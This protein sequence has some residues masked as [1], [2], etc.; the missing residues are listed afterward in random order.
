MS[1]IKIS[2]KPSAT[3]RYC[4]GLL[5]FFLL[6]FTVILSQL[7]WPQ[8]ADKISLVLSAFDLFFLELLLVS[9]LGYFLIQRSL[10]FRVI[11]YLFAAVFCL[12][13]LIQTAAFYQTGKFVTKL[14]VENINHVAIIFNTQNILLLLILLSLFILFVWFVEK[15]K[16][17]SINTAH[18]HQKSFILILG[19]SLLIVLSNALSWWSESQLV[20]RN[21]FLVKNQLQHIPPVL[22]FYKLFFSKT[23]QSAERLT[24]STL[25]TA[26]NYGFQYKEN[27]QYPLIK[28]SIYHGETPFL[29]HDTSSNTQLPNIIIFFV[30]GFSARTSD[31][32]STVYKDITPNLVDFAKH[33]LVIDNYYNHTAATYRGL[34]GQLCSIYPKFGG[35][36]GGWE[37]NYADLPH[38]NYFCLT[39]ELKNYSYRSIFLHSQLAEKTYLNEMMSTLLT[40]QYNIV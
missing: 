13:N 21:Q 7:D 38:I 26:R 31:V 25:A 30:E 10:F 37:D 8:G 40:R 12:V 35:H 39:D 36:G 16:H 14:A 27:V 9:L 22:S 6:N 23:E 11:A 3:M 2:S 4:L 28:D 20:L 29:K 34:H 5:I 15:A 17:Q 18:T 33:S 1:H 19:I 24:E 32:Y